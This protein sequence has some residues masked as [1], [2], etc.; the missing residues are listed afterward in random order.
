MLNRRIFASLLALALAGAAPAWAD[1]GKSGSGGSGSS[2]SGGGDDDGGSDGGGS[3]GSGGSGGDDSGGSSGSDGGGG[4]GS[5]SGG[6]SGSG[7]GDS[8]SSGHGG[9]DN[10]RDDQKKARDAVKDGKAVPLREVMRAVKSKYK[11]DVVSVKLRGKGSRLTY[12]IKMVADDG[13]L[14]TIDADA[15]TKRILKVAGH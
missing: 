15:R 6:D 3:S 2:G 11:G 5:G 9:G 10:D 14:L 12:R 7:G 4:S 13:R 1:G 8:G